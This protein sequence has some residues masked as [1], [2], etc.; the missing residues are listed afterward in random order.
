M[1]F[2]DEALRPSRLITAESRQLRDRCASTRRDSVRAR[3]RAA[4]THE[5]LRETL[6][7]HGLRRMPAIRGSSDLDGQS[8]NGDGDRRRLLVRA[9]AAHCPVQLRVGPSGGATC[10]LCRA[11]IPTGTLQYDIDAGCGM[12]IVD[13]NCYMSF[14]QDVVEATPAAATDGLHS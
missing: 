13:D 4:A 6:M 14:L 12:I 10:M 7:R 3:S 9:I 8:V 5:Q 11:A 1:H 2:V